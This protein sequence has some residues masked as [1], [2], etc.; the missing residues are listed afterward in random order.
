MEGNSLFAHV[1]AQKVETHLTLIVK[2]Y[3][4]Y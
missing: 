4:F 1:I 3:A 2:T